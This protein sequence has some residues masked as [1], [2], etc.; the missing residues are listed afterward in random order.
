MRL[1]GERDVPIRRLPRDGRIFSPRH[2]LPHPLGQHSPEVSCG[3]DREPNKDDSR[4][5]YTHRV[6]MEH[7]VREAPHHGEWQRFKGIRPR[8]GQPI[9]RAD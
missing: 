3:R 4:S 5:C 6:S 9:L 8:A 1:Q 2:T 7:R